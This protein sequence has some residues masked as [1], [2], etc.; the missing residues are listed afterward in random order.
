MKRG[1]KCISIQLFGW[2]VALSLI[3]VGVTGAQM[4][5]VQSTPADGGVSVDTVVTLSLTFNQAIDTTAGFEL[6]E[7]E[8]F[9]GIEL[10]P[11]SKIGEPDSITLSPDSM[12]VYFVNLQLWPD[13]K[14]VLV[15]SGARSVTGDLLDKPYVINFTT[16]A[17]LPENAVSGTVTYAGGDPTNTVVAL[18]TMGE[19]GPEYAGATVVSAADGLYAIPFVE[20]GE[21]LGGAILDDNGNGVL[22]PWGGDVMGW[23]DPDDN[24]IL[25]MINVAGNVDG[26]NFVIGP[27]VPQTARTPLVQ[28]N[29]LAQGMAPDAQLVWVEGEGV[30]SAGTGIMWFYWYAS[31]NL[32]KALSFTTIGSAILPIGEED[33]EDVIDPLPT[34]WI[35]S[36]QAFGITE[37]NGGASFRSEHADWQIHAI[38]S[39]RFFGGDEDEASMEKGQSAGWQSLRRFGSASLPKGTS[40]VQDQGFWIILYQSAS[41]GDELRIILDAVTGEIFRPT[42]ARGSLDVAEAEGMAWDAEAVLA[43]VFTHEDTVNLAGHSGSWIY[44]YYSQTRDS[45]YAVVTSNGLVLFGIHEEGG[46]WTEALPDNWLDSDSARVLAESYGG[47]NFRTVHGSV[48]V[49]AGVARGFDQGDPT[50]AVW[51]FRYVSGEEEQTVIFDAVTGELVTGIESGRLN[52][53]VPASFELYQNF[54]NPFNPETAIGFGVPQQDH[55]R[56]RILDLLGREVTVLVDGEK[57]P[58]IYRAVWD[59]RDTRGELVSSGIYLYELK[60]SS[61]RRVRRMLLLR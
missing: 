24:G 34:D 57:T 23:Y 61:F 16:G 26:I 41:T 17:S 1:I 29:G 51:F 43:A 11:L 38:L 4:T 10:Y 54:P 56:L 20:Q 58:G 31:V 5:F 14:Y 48:N 39:P 19:E 22:E 44:A 40:V 3:L 50:R 45:S 12:T 49:Y 7:G 8:F 47:S 42:T 52:A 36:D 27:V 28:L 18:L 35:D 13:T 59:G 21:Y 15:L 60:A 37:A 6:E 55:V 53:E 30:D 9:L 32:A 25:D 46:E 2:G 33:L